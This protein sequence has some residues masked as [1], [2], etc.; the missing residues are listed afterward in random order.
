[1]TFQHIDPST[2][3]AGDLY[4]SCSREYAI[5]AARSAGDAQQVWRRRPLEE[6]I[7]VWPRAAA[8]LRERR[9]ALARRMADEMGKPLDQGRSEVDKCAWLCEYMAEIAPDA[10]APVRVET[11]ASW[12]GWVHTPLGVVLAVMPWNFPFW[13]VFR[14]AVPALTAGNAVLLK[15]APNVPGCAADCVR[16]LDDAGLPQGLFVNLYAETETVGEVIEDP[17]VQGVT[18]TGSVAAGRAVAAR[19]GRALKKTVLELGGSDPYLILEDADLDLAAEKCVTS[20]LVNSGQSCIAAKR[21]IA[22]SRIHDA[23]VER[24]RARLAEAVVGDPREPGTTV[25]PLAREDLRDEVHRQ[26]R[27]S[28][29][30][31]A[32]LVMGGDLPARDGWWYPVTLLTGVTAGMPAGSEEIFGPVA[33]VTRAADEDEAIGIAN[34]TVYGLGAAVFTRDDARGRAIAAHRLEAGSCFVNDYVASD[35]RLPFGGIRQSGYGREL[36]PLSLREFVN[37]KT[38]QVA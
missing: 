19:A 26:V 35:P 16:L 10:L 18:L 38:V 8:L 20:R 13:Q 30:A 2:G 7:A 5:G 31:G 29:D 28:V 3:T 22:V 32:T 36:S 27:D 15:H 33:S 24:V 4:E 25:G 17:A 21:F 34:R 1:M 23:F 6:R 11:D 14:A 9:E 12:S 37:V